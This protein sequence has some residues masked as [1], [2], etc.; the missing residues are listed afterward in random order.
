MQH[1]FRNLQYRNASDAGRVRRRV[2]ALAAALLLTACGDSTAGLFGEAL[3][4]RS[5]AGCHLADGSG[6][7]GPAVGPGSDSVELTDEQLV[8]AIRVGPGSMPGFRRF[9]DEQVESLVVYLRE[10]QA[11]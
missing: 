3:Y 11:R 9:S 2:V 4:E 8:G 1:P 7:G 6:A 10:L 5:C